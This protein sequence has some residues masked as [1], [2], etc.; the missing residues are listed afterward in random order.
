[1][2]RPKH[3][4]AF[5]ITQV[6][7]VIYSPL[8]HRARIQGTGLEVFEIVYVY[9]SVGRS[10][11]HLQRAFNWLTPEQLRAALAFAEKNPEFVNA[12]L[13]QQDAALESLGEARP[14]SDL[15]PR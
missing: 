2:T 5:P 4:S 1:M 10:W 7:G 14:S 15:K 13:E 12:E 9:R 8:E 11:E 3:Q 6:P